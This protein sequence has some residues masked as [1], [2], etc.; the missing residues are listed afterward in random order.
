MFSTTI[1][2]HILNQKYFLVQAL[3]AI[4]E[5]YF[6]ALFSY[7]PL[8]IHLPHNQHIYSPPPDILKKF[9]KPL[10]NVQTSRSW[11]DT[12]SYYVSQTK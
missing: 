6:L 4:K 7:A 2:F 12:C 5:N 11:G 3:L 10:P 1:L 8:R 9:A